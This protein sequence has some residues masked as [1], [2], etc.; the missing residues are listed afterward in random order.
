M[1]HRD[2]DGVDGLYIRNWLCIAY[3]WNMWIVCI[4]VIGYVQHIVGLCG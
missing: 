4:F 1:E 2:K 3:S